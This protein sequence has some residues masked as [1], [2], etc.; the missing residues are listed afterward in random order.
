MNCQAFHRFFSD[1]LDGVLDAAD[2]IRV[3][4]HL[5]ACEACRRSEAA[6]HAG[7]AALR[8]AGELCPSRDLGVRILHGIRQERRLP[9]PSGAYGVV[10]TLLLATLL[11]AVAFDL[12][13]LGVT[14][15]HEPLLAQADSAPPSPSAV[16]LDH[17]ILRLR[18]ASGALLGDPYAVIS[19]A[20]P[21]P[22]LRGRTEI[23]AVWPG[24]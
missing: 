4:R 17:A 3:R 1:Y 23:P 10:G 21:D 11:A 13:E 6:Y 19:A 12:K 14:A 20:D 5:D 18:D 8:G 22:S 16:T 2:A 7:I 9:A 15:P 24:R